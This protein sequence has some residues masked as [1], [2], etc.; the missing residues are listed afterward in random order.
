MRPFQRAFAH[1]LGSG[2]RRGEA[3]GEGRRRPMGRPFVRNGDDALWLRAEA[4][5]RVLLFVS[6][7]IDEPIAMG[8]PF[9]MNTRE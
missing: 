9:V 3:T 8:G 7:I 4:A 6:P 1:V 2:A 5:S